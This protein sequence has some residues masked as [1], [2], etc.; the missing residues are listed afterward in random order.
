M[1][2][3][4]GCVGVWRCMVQH[5]LARQ[6][7]NVAEQRGLSGCVS[8]SSGRAGAERF[9]WISRGVS[10]LG[11][12]GTADQVV[13]GVVLRCSDLDQENHMVNVIG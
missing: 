6:A 11:M 13:I 9:V 2:W 3:Q 12:A 1:F 8:V 7:R 10:R 5:V 4:A